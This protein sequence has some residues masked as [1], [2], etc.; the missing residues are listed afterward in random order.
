MKMERVVENEKRRK[1]KKKSKMPG[2]ISSNTELA[3][4][5]K[6]KEE[7]WARMCFVQQLKQQQQHNDEIQRV[8]TLW[9]Q[10]RQV[11]VEMHKKV[12][13][14]KADLEKRLQQLEAEN[15]RQKSNLAVNSQTQEKKLGQLQ[16]EKE[17]LETEKTDLRKQKAEL[18]DQL[19][20][21][22]HEK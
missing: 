16:S 10:E 12:V 19:R 17:A 11:R 5:F 6:Q 7:E 21:V 13:A 1:K 22:R 20:K 2:D 3:Q 9:K 15:E 18:E 14:A 4:A 8:K